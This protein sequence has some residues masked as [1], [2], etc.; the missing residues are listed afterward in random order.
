[1]FFILVR[2]RP[3]MSVLL[4]ALSSL[5][6]RP[7]QLGGTLGSQTSGLRGLA[8]PA[9]SLDSLRAASA[10]APVPTSLVGSLSSLAAVK[11]MPSSLA[12]G[13]GT[14]GASL[15]SL[16]TLRP[17]ATVAPPQLPQLPQ[18]SLSSL[19][20]AT[21]VS[22]LPSSLGAPALAPT[23]GA[24]ASPATASLPPPSL[25]S[26][27]SIA[28]LQSLQSLQSLQPLSGLSALS[29]QAPLSSAPLVPPTNAAPAVVLRARPTP[30]T[31][32]AN[33]GERTAVTDLTASAKADSRAPT[34]RR[35][36]EL[37]VDLQAQWQATL[38]ATSRH[39]QPKPSVFGRIVCD[40]MTAPPALTPGSAASLSA[41]CPPTLEQLYP[42]FL[43]RISPLTPSLFQFDT[44]SPDDVVRAAQTAGR[45]P[46]AAVA[47]LSISGKAPQKPTAA[48]AAAAAPS[49]KSA[50]PSAS[51]T[52]STPRKPSTSEADASATPGAAEKRAS[53]AKLLKFKP[54]IDVLK[55]YEKHQATSK[56]R[57]NLVVVG[58]VDAGKSTLMGHLLFLIGDVD[59]RQ[60]HKFESESK[61]SG[62]ASFKFAWVLDETGEER[63]RGVTIDIAQRH[64]ET[65]TKSI[66]LLDA[67]GHRDFIPNMITG[68]AQAD[69]AVLVINAT[70]GE[71]E[72]GF[73]LGGQT[74]EH[75]LLLRSLGVAQVII[76]VNK[77]DTIDWSQGRFEEIREKM[78][79]FL[80]SSGFKDQNITFVPVSGLAGENLVKPIMTVDWY[81]GPALVDL[82]DNLKVTPRALD[83]PF[84]FTVSDV[85][86]GFGA[87]VAVAGKVE[88]GFAQVGEPL[89]VQ[90]SGA[91][92]SVKSV[93]TNESSS[94]D[95]VVAG[96]TV[97]LMLN[98][99]DPTEIRVGSVLCAHEKPMPVAKQ[100]RAQLIVFDIFVPIT[101]GTKVVFH[102]GQLNEPAAI[103]K[104]V[105]LLNKATGEVTKSRPR[106]LTKQSTAVVDLTLDFPVCIDTAASNKA[107]SRFMLR[108]DGKTIAA[109]IVTEVL[110]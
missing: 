62:K 3:L 66:T 67:P 39:C 17:T 27:P 37:L 96:D 53:T 105:S 5:A 11:P 101:P 69:V 32:S 57:V 9:A 108:S 19:R 107:L 97:S 56:Q 78:K 104:L 45:K 40:Q 21:G 106:C 60:M 43:S 51:D 82:I 47:S 99:L 10:A 31:L 95:W 6:A 70:T 15:A 44:P 20:P 90:P 102:Y 103:T 18:A 89:L 26:A 87:A 14:G 24:P 36:E 93:D 41:T 46:A 83:G 7:S 94:R 86:K 85:F 58:H 63:S 12:G 48:T 84:R 71:F 88:S 23:L 49:P 81:K 29:Q 59:Q 77:M 22:Q 1:M 73:D 79:P 74:R 61:K 55:E 68:A 25:A 42:S 80:K 35:P 34:K 64:F 109:G 38:K 52:K 72:A 75:A 100:I 33:P 92:C 4:S 65:T 2:T 30:H 50:A 8:A 76:A 16:A 98:N 91:I 54:T 13:L 28:P 110:S